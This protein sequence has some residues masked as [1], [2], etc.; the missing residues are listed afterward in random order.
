MIQP[1]SFGQVERRD[2]VCIVP[3]SGR[4]AAGLNDDQLRQRAREIK[5]LDCRGLVADIRAL[6][7]I[8]SSGISFFRRASYLSHETPAWT[9]RPPRPFASCPRNTRNDSP[10]DDPGRGRRPRV[11]PR[12]LR[13]ARR[14]R[15]SHRLALNHGATY[16]VPPNPSSAAGTAVPSRTPEYATS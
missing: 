13:A 8:G 16:T 11:C 14:V 9:F 5:S 10:D 7:S 4:L 3:I 1:L 12:L 6:D 15:H 2:D